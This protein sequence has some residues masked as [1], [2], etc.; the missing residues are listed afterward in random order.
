MSRVHGIG[1]VTSLKKIQHPSFSECARV[2]QDDGSLKEDII[3]AG[4]RAM[5][6]VYG[7][8]TEESLNSLR[9]RKFCSKSATN[10]VAVQVSSLPPTSAAMKF[11]SLRVYYQI[12]EWKGKAQ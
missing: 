11:H 12:Q 2:F 3:T 6:L 4:E 8:G 9:H 10:T 7:G 5:V 1:K